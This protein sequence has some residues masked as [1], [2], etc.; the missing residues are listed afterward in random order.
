MT[1]VHLKHIIKEYL[2]DINEFLKEKDLENFKQLESSQKDQ[3]NTKEDKKEKKS[4]YKQF[5]FKISV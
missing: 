1:D 3:K 2:G 5:S 4:F